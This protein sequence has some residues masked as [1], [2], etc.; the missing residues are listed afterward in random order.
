MGGTANF[1]HTVVREVEEDPMMDE[2]VDLALRL[3]K[4]SLFENPLPYARACAN[5]FWASA[6]L[7]KTGLLTQHLAR[8]QDSLSQAVVATSRFMD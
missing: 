1:G 4:R 7:G 6:R 8:V 3:L 5:M 2:F